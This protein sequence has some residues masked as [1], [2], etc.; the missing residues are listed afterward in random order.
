[1]EGL[2]KKAADVTFM[3]E[4]KSI[5]TMVRELETSHQSSGNALKIQ[6]YSYI[7]N[8]LESQLNSSVSRYN[9]SFL[10]LYD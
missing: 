5:L 1:M 3:K 4:N 2:L 7:K 10:G 8:L 9:S 6:Y